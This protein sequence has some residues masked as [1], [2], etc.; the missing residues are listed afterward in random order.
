MKKNLLLSLIFC[1]ITISAMEHNSDT[2]EKRLLRIRSL[3]NLENYTANPQVSIEPHPETFDIRK[4]QSLYNLGEQLQLI[5]E[6]E[7]S[8]LQKIKSSSNQEEFNPRKVY[9]SKKFIKPRARIK[10]TNLSKSETDPE[11]FD[12]REIISKNII[13]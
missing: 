9:D 13:T 2:S 5:S 12:A 8:K 3:S 4:T 7:R 1:C 6:I 11:K 10:K